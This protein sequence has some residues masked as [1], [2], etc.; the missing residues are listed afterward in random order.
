[1]TGPSA[2]C[3]T[4]DAATRE[5]SAVAPVRAGEVAAGYR[6]SD[7]AGQHLARIGALP[8]MAAVYEYSGRV[9]LPAPVRAGG[10]AG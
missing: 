9:A 1:M 8:R 2:P 7:D 4:P 3:S 10:G 5:D 6:L